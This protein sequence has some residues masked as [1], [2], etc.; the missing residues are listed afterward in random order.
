MEN[1]MARIIVSTDPTIDRDAPVLLDERVY[2]VHL[3]DGHNASELVER[4]GWA[5][6]DA[7]NIQ[8][9]NRRCS[10]EP[11]IRAR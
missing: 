5:I 9:T 11:A 8:Q 6:N 1:F 2:S 4:L 10:R 7:E 3:D